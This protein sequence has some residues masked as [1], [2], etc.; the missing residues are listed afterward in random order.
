LR[1]NATDAVIEDGTQ[2]HG[3]IAMNAIVG[4]EAPTV[5]ESNAP[6]AAASLL[7]MMTG[8]WVAQAI[9]V[10]AKLELADVLA[11]GPADVDVLASASGAN[12]D[13]LYRLLRALSRVGV[14]NEVAPRSFALTPMAELLRSGTPQSMRALAMTYNEEIYRAWGDLLYS[15]RTGKPA[16][17]HV[18]GSG[19]FQYFAQHPEADRTFNE[20]LVGYTNQVAEAVACTYDFSSARTVVDIGG[21]YGRLLASILQV[22]PDATGVLFEQA[23][24]VAG[25]R[26]FLAANGVADRCACVAGDFFEEVPCFADIYLL[27]QILHD[28]DDARCSVILRSCRRAIRTDGRLL[29]VEYVLGSKQGAAFGEWLDLNMLVCPGGRER[30][31]GEYAALLGEA[32]FRLEKVVPTLAG[33]SIIEAVPV[34]IGC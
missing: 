9:Y 6:P 33:P 21:G 16:F 23:H 29:V 3:G 10:A 1:G 18:F 31:R 28:W 34:A 13:A 22:S 12:T 2:R 5:L 11:Q 19:P 20:A 24:V 4:D 26:E 15:V 17:E 32:G 8:Y 7:R 25:A 30:T 14:F 27:S